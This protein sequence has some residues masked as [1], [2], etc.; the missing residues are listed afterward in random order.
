MDKVIVLWLLLFLCMWHERG[1]G[2]G[3]DVI[4]MEHYAT[5]LGSISVF[6]SCVSCSFDSD[7]DFL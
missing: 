5:F 7:Q 1:G 6:E 2:K 4:M 3:E